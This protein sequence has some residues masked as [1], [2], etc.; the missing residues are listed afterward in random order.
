MELEES[1]QKA[2]KELEIA[3]KEVEMQMGS[4]KCNYEREI[5][6][7][8]TTLQEHKEALDVINKRKRELEIE[9]EVLSYQ[10]QENNRKKNNVPNNDNVHVSPYKTNFLLELEKLLNETTADVE[11]VL[12]SVASSKEAITSGGMSLHEMQLLVREAAERCR[13]IGL[14]YVSLNLFLKYQFIFIIIFLI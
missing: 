10:I 14:N 7:L 6:L 8:G 2:I 11:S 5:K 12:S 9:K 4:Q 13:D 1:K 3:K